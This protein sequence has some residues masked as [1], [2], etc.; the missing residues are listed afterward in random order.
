MK[1]ELIFEG[2]E[3]QLLTCETIDKAQDLSF[4]QSSCIDSFSF[5]QL[6]TD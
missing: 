1:V 6:I 3:N 4:N 5:W 2:F